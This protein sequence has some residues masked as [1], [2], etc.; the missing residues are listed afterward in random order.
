MTYT[1]DSN[2]ISGL[3]AS[4]SS[5]R[6]STYIQKSG[7]GSKES[8]LQLYL[9]NA[10]ISAKFHFPLQIAEITLR[11]ALH[12]EMTSAYGVSWPSEPSL[13]FHNSEKIKISKAESDI[14]NRR[15][16]ITPDRIVAGLTFGFWTTL[17][18]SGRK[19]HY[20]SNLWIPTLNKAFK[21]A[22]IK[23]RKTI[24]SKYDE[25]RK[26]RNRIAHHEPIFAQNLENK[27][28]TALEI[29]AWHCPITADWVE[30]HSG[31]VDCLDRKPTTR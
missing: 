4:L 24:H 25:L 20:H 9:W 7:D 6:L 31:I 11:N 12:L 28:R 2:K 27:Y 10:E 8:A 18:G 23:K 21:K 14:R 3:E 19:G 1:Y 29:I 17:I 15:Q 30:H 22:S 16:T 13:P 26:L 5:A